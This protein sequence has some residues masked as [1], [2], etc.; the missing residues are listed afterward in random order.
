M[1]DFKVKEKE[2][3]KRE[4]IN[5]FL[6]ISEAHKIWMLKLSFWRSDIITAN[7]IFHDFIH[8]LKF[9]IKNGFKIYYVF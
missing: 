2:K 8:W 4:K 6:S 3:E 1:T 5:S 7:I 9:L